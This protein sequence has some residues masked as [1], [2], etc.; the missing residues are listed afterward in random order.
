MS[1]RASISA[2]FS[3][4]SR[5]VEVARQ[6]IHY[7]ETGQ[8]SPILF[9]H[10]NPTSSYL[11]RNIMPYAAGQGRAIAMDLIGMGK[12]DKP[13]I[14]YR[15]FDH[16]TYVDGFID[17]LG[18]KDVTLVIHDWGSGLGFHYARRHAENVRAIAFMEAIIRPV[19]W[20]DFPP[21]FKTGFKLMRTP[22]VGWMMICGLNVFVNKI[23]PSATVRSLSDKEMARYREPYPNV[24]SRRPVRRWPQEIPIDGHPADI[25]E[26]VSAYSAWLQETEI[27][28]LL[29]YGEPG[30]LIREKDVAWCREHIKNFTAVSIGAGIHYLQEDNPHRIGEQL[31]SWIAD[32]KGQTGR[33][34]DRD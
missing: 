11:W 30:G 24:R 8:G 29:F 9:L 10:G 5:F 26:V 19:W 32:L 15:F 34:V 33:A 12:S 3:F 20:S 16:V 7:V 13:D 25:H 17:A 14:A 6:R 23:L 4:E 27:P 28:M 2:D 31:A 1:E 22:G 21:D 18:L